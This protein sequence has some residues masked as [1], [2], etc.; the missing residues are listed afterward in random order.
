[1]SSRPTVALLGTGT[2]GAGMARNLAAAGLPLRVW[3]RSPERAAPLADV[4]TVAQTAAEAVDG[5]DVVVTMTY[6]GPSVEA[7]IDAARG[8]LAPGTVWVQAATVGVEATEQLVALARELDL[9][10]VDAP[11][12]GTKKPAEDGT[13]VVLA[14]GPD[15]AQP[16]LAPVFDA[17]GSRTLWVGPA[18]AGT[19]LKLVANGWVLTVL[20]GVADSMA[21]ARD[22]GLDPQLFLEAV[23]GGAMDAPYVQLKGS[24]MLADEMAPSFAL[25]GALKDAEL[26]LAAAAEAGT[27]LAA[28]PGIRDHLRRAVDDGHG[29]LD[30][31]ATWKAH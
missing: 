13:L 5:A 1:M 24:A 27:D 18:G 2:M 14:S 15:S 8:G 28:L 19:R 25:S 21:L 23:R 9:V 20:E 10:F 31:A 4:A 12:L 17:I 6:D 22:L 29:D 7:A 30:M 11:V 26:V 16:V 3:N